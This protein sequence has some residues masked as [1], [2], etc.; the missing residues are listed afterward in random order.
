MENV[1]LAPHWWQ[2]PALEPTSVPQAGHNRGRAT[3]GCE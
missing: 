2:R 3:E 1:K